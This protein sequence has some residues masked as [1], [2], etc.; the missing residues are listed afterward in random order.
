TLGAQLLVAQAR[1]DQASASRAL[2]D[3]KGAAAAF[4]EARRL[5]SASGDHFGEAK[6]LRG[7]G[8]ILLDHGDYPNAKKNLEDSLRVLRQIG[9][10]AVETSVLGQLMALLYAQGDLNGAVQIGEQYLASAREIGDLRSQAHALNV[11]ALIE[12][13]RGQFPAAEKHFD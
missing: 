3:P 10:R 6:A 1:L 13:D 12:S 5:F 11:M 2:G 7:Y 8:V 4:E 9:N